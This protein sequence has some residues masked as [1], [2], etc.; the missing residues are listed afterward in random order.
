MP[1]AGRARS[2]RCDLAGSM[3]PPKLIET[4][5]LLLR[6]P[7]LQDAASIF[8]RYARDPDVTRYLTWRPHET[9]DQTREF[10]NRCCRFWESGQA[11]PWAIVH[12]GETEPIGMIDLRPQGER[13]EIGYVLARAFWRRGYMTEA[14]R[15]VVDWTL[16][17]PAIYRVWAVCDVENA[18]SAKVLEKLGMRRE[19]VLRRWVVHPNVDALPRDC[20]CYAI[21]K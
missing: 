19:G 13:A 3:I 6:P 5:R 14:A 10:L 9:V 7:V 11:F 12:R 17:R 18:G 1:G 4:P 21:T 2:R 15:A 8:E 16:G 20:Y